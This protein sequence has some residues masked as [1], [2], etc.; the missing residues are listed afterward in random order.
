M[1]LAEEL[2]E[3]EVVSEVSS[4]QILHG[5]VEVLSVLEG[6]NHIDNEGVA[7]LLEDGLLVDDRA[8]TF[9]E[10]DSE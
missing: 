6:R 1:L 10:K 3:A 2:V 4:S 5:H 8:H 7:Q 9:L